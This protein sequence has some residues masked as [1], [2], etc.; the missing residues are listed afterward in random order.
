MNLY[1]HTGTGILEVR[2]SSKC[3]L[4]ASGDCLT[5]ASKEKSVF[6]ELPQVIEKM[7]K[8]LTSRL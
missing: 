8:P 7:K 4:R 2:L 6:F 5:P 1:Y 3:I